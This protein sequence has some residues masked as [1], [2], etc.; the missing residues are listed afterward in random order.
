MRRSTGGEGLGE[1]EVTN[2]TVDEEEVTSLINDSVGEV[3]KE[4]VEK[5]EADEVESLRECLAELG[6]HLW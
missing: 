1:D 3:S 2:L 5:G 4:A 6:G